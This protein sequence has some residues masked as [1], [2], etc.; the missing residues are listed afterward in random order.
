MKLI[1]YLKLLLK[2]LETSEVSLKCVEIAEKWR[3]PP[4]ISPAGLDTNKTTAATGQERPTPRAISE[5]IAKIRSTAKA[6][7]TTSHFSISSVK[8]NGGTPRKNSANAKVKK[9]TSK[10]ANGAKAGAGKRKRGG[11]IGEEYVYLLIYFGSN[12]NTNICK[13]KPVT[14]PKL[15]TSSLTTMGLRP[16]TMRLPRRS[17]RPTA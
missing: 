6:S 9:A 5:R 13:G 14:T 8:S 10:K 3:K 11:R 17:Q 16:V 4:L 12:C 1:H 2:I 7:G 15:T